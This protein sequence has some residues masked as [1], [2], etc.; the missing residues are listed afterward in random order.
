MNFNIFKRNKHKEERALTYYSDALNFNNYSSFSANYAM[1]LSAVYRAVELIS[2]SVAML[3]IYVQFTDNDGYKTRYNEHSAN[4]LLNEQPNELMTRYQFIKLLLIDVMLRGNAFAYIKRDDVGNCI[5][6]VYLR[7]DTVTIDYNELT[8]ELKYRC[9]TVTGIIEPCNMIHLVKYSNDG[10][11]GISILQNAKNTL[12]LTNDTEKQASNFFRSGCALAGVLTVQGQLQD[13]QK[14]QIRSSWNS[15]YNSDG[16]GLAVLQGNMSYQPISINATDAQ[17]LES[18]LFNVSDIA[19]FFSISPVLLGDLSKSSYSTLEQSQL[20][21][22]SQTLQPYITMIEQEFSRKIFRPS[23]I[24]LS[25]NIDEKALIMTDKAALASYYVQMLQNGLMTSNEIRK[26]LGLSSIEGGDVT[27]MQA[28]YLQQ[29]NNN[30]VNT[31]VED[32]TENL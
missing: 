14:E 27:V 6:L 4:K 10:I 28:Q 23:E 32:D 7:P 1:R 21:F 31:D 24:N 11:N 8:R 25:V 29:Q 17:L 18:R 15:A 20:Q 2:D 13:K 16:S 3:P 30:M 9:N 26:E 19:R 5:E 12:A 22:L